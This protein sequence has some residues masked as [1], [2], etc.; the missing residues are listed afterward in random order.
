MKLN[1]SR[2]QRSLERLHKPIYT[3]SSIKSSRETTRFH[4]IIVNRQATL[5]WL[6]PSLLTR[7]FCNRGS[8]CRHRTRFSAVIQSPRAIRTHLYMYQKYFCIASPIRRTR[9]PIYH[10]SFEPSFKLRGVQL[11]THGRSFAALSDQT[12]AVPEAR[13]CGSSRT[14]HHYSNHD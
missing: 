7:G 10:G 2:Q 12:T 1:D 13:W 6:C 4:I 3:K 11:L 8:A 14:L 5:S 9:A